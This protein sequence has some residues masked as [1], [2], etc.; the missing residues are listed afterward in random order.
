MVDIAAIGGALSAL[1][2][3]G[4][5]AKGMIGLNDAAKIQGKVIEL[6]SA[7]LAAQSSALSAQ[8]E[9]SSL[10]NRIGDLEKEIAKV[11]AWE[12]EKKNYELSELR[13]GAFAYRF[14]EEVD[15]TKPAHEICATCYEGGIKSIL[16]HD[17]VFPGKK[18]IARCDACGAVITITGPA[19]PTARP[20]VRVRRPG[21]R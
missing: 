4:E 3:A 6:Q 2:T 17:T 12:A 9:Q 11:K 16:Q 10:L 8:A 13:P 7:I 5:I 18:K 14:K 20:A 1:Q 15:P 21:G 19:E